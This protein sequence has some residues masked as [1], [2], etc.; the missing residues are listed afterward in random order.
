MQYILTSDFPEET[1]HNK[2]ESIQ[3]EQNYEN[4]ITLTSAGKN[5]SPLSKTASQ[6]D[7]KKNK[8]PKKCH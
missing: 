1:N 3:T 5:P 2:N 4:T 6:K 7:L 8:L